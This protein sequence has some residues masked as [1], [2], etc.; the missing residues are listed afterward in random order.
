[1]NAIDTAEGQ[2]EFWTLQQF[3]VICGKPWFALY[4]Q[5]DQGILEKKI[6]RTQEDMVENKTSRKEQQD[7]IDKD[8]LGLA[9]VKARQN[10]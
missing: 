3:T 5:N 8:Q 6:R 1:M 2:G 9:A 4:R 10:K 7:E